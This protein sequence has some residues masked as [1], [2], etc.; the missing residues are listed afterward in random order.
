ARFTD[1]LEAPD[2][3]R[4]EVPPAEAIFSRIAPVFIPRCGE[5]V[6]PP[7]GSHIVS[8]FRKLR[9]NWLLLHV[10]PKLVRSLYVFGNGFFTVGL[11]AVLATLVEFG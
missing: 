6:A 3:S 8:F 4:L 7:W 10:P 11:L 1:G 5:S 9:L 2:R